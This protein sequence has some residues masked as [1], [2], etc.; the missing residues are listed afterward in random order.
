MSGKA[1]SRSSLQDWRLSSYSAMMDRDNVTQ[2][3]AEGPWGREERSSPY[4]GT[5]KPGWTWIQ[6]QVFLSGGTRAKGG[7]KWT[8]AKV[9]RRQA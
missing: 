3:R 6:S 8:A 7:S 1:K 9:C 5:L 4:S 2:T